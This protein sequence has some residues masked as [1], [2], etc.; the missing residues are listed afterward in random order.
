MSDRVGTPSPVIVFLHAGDYDRVH[1]GLAIASAAVASGRKTEIYFFWWA[2]ERLVLGRLDEPDFEREDVADRFEARA[3]PTLRSM[4]EF[5]RGSPDCA[6]FACTGSLAA[7]GI[8]SEQ[9]RPHVHQL[10]GWS[11]ILQRTGGA[12]DRFYL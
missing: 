6:L 10:V 7:L 5:L 1:Q 9:V 3:L 11:A 12:T 8:T 4:L 2:L